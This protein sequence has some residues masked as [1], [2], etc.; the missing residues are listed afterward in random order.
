MFHRFIF[1]VL[2]VSFSL[3]HVLIYRFAVYF[4]SFM[5]IARRLEVLKMPRASN[6]F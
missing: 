1:H 4:Q 2:I 3:L 5:N 6:A